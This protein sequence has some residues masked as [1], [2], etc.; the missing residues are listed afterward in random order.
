MRINVVDDDKKLLL[1][2]HKDNIKKTSIFYYFF[3]L[4]IISE[5]FNYKNIFEMIYLHHEYF[6]DWCWRT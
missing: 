2:K 4:F 6:I 3:L 1:E 5:G